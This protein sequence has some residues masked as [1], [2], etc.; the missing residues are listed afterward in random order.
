[1]R[2]ASGPEGFLP[3]LGFKQF[4]GHP[5]DILL[6]DFVFGKDLLFDP[7]IKIRVGCIGLSQHYI[8][9]T[10]RENCPMYTLKPFWSVPAIPC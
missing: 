1:M 10:I 2:I 7:L 4:V 9:W 6:E 5:S 8:R 3:G